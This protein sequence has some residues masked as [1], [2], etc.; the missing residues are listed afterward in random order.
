MPEP[1]TDCHCINC[2]IDRV[3]TEKT[4]QTADVRYCI[5]ALGE[6][7]DDVSGLPITMP[8]DDFKDPK[9]MTGLMLGYSM[10]MESLK[11]PETVIPDIG[12]IRAV[13]Q[14]CLALIGTLIRDRGI[15]PPANKNLH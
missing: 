13:I 1:K 9:M 5:H 4:P 10:A 11:W 2:T 15:N 8:E 12:T 6:Y 14:G 3:M 7:L